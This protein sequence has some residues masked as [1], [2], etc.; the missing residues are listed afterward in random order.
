MQLQYMASGGQA[1]GLVP[2][3]PLS[4]FAERCYT[5]GKI[6]RTIQSANLSAAVMPVSHVGIRHSL[7][8]DG[9]DGVTHRG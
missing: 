1:D 5:I 8:T 7:V 6:S 9:T 2:V 3:H 4:Q